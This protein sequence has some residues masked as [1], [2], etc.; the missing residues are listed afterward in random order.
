MNGQLE[1]GPW[2]AIHEE[3]GVKP[4]DFDDRPPG[5]FLEI[6]AESMPDNSALLNRAGSEVVNLYVE[7]TPEA[8]QLDPGQVRADILEFCRAEVAA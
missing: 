8:R 1:L 6:H 5:T 2:L 4:P 7:L 3:L